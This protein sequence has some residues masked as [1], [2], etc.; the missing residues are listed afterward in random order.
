MEIFDFLSLL[1]LLTRQRTGVQCNANDQ[2]Q[3]VVQAVGEPSMMYVIQEKIQSNMGGK[4][5]PE[6]SKYVWMGDF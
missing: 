1:V 3:Y 5:E 2:N 4:I 6:D